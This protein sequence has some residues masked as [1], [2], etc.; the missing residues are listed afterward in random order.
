MFKTITNAIQLTA[1]ALNKLVS[2]PEPDCLGSFVATGVVN[3]L[4]A[5][6]AE[7]AVE[8]KRMTEDEFLMRARDAFRE[9]EKDA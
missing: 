9:A 7:V 5:A 1:D 6:V 3:D 8:S 4:M 2:A